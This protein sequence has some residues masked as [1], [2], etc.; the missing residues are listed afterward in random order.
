MRHQGAGGVDGP[1]RPWTV[2]TVRAVNPPPIAD[3][4]PVTLPD[5]RPGPPGDLTAEVKAL[6][7]LLAEV[8]M[9]AAD[10]ALFPSRWALIAELALEHDS[11][12]AALQAEATGGSA[13]LDANPP[14]LRTEHIITRLNSL[15]DLIGNNHAR[16]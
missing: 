7:E 14:P 8:V 12:R 2:R 4:P 9:L 10:H 3:R 16:R 13:P 15:R 6:A 11:V 1:A 5:R